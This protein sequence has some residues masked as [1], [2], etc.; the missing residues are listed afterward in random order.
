[1]KIYGFLIPVVIDGDC[2]VT[3]GHAGIEA[4]RRPGTSGEQS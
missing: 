4:A 3:P 2:N 1:M